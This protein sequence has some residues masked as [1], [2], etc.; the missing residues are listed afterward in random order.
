MGEDLLDG[1]GERPGEPQAET[2]NIREGAPTAVT[3]FLSMP[4]PGGADSQSTVGLIR[5][6]EE[7]QLAQ[8][9]LADSDDEGSVDLLGMKEQIKSQEQHR[10]SNKDD[11]NP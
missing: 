2:K 1:F 10:Q 3:D 7:K 8:G 6:E 9:L 4:L 11:F 5:A